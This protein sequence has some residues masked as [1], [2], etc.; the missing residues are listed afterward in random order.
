MKKPRGVNPIDEEKPN[1]LSGQLPIMTIEI[2]S[3]TGQDVTYTKC[4]KCRDLTS[5]SVSSDSQ[6]SHSFALAGTS[7]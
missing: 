6:I 7:K 2:T 3:C 5:K 1:L 4:S